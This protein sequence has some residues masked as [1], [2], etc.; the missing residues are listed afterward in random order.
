MRERSSPQLIRKIRS[1]V[2]GEIIRGHLFHSP[3]VEHALAESQCA[4]LFIY[5]DPR[6]VVCSEAHYLSKMNWW[7]RMHRTF[8]SLPDDDARIRFAIEGDVQ[9]IAPVP[10][11]NVAARFAAYS[12]WLQAPSVHSIRFEEL[13]GKGQPN[14]V[15]E[16]LAY[17]EDFI[18]GLDSNAA[19][20]C[21]AKICPEKSHTFRKGGGVG[22]WK[23]QFTQEHKELFKDVA[24]DLLIQL[25][26]E[27]D[28]HW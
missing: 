10:Y 17:L 7:H 15:A 2:P 20:K 23:R 27:R 16:I 14:C 25:G 1:W 22:N 26:Y 12:N 5:R 18:G 3:I 6:D 13:I 24:G 11:K 19:I 8:S 21:Q 28:T 4:H 9:M